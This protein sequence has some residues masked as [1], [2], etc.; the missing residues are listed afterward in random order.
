VGTQSPG[1]NIVITNNGIAEVAIASVSSPAAPFSI[2]TSTCV[3]LLPAGASCV[4]T[5]VFAPTSPTASS[6]TIV[7][8][9]E[10][11][12]V[13]T[14]LVGTGRTPTGP[15]PGFLTIKPVSANFGNAVVGTALPAKNFV[16]TNPGQSAVVVTSVG[17]G[18]T[19]ADQFTV[20]S[21]G[22]S[23]SLAAK[24]SC[25]IQVAATVTRDGAQTAT[26]DVLGAGGAAAHATLRI[27]GE[28]TP[29]LK[30]VPGVVSPGEV[31]TAIG[32]GF[33]PG[34]DVQL[35]FNGEAPF[36][37]VPTQADGTFRYSLLL[38]P[39]SVRIGGRQVVVV[40][41]PE[42]SG[43]FAP[44]LIELATSRP[45][46]FSNPQFTSGVRALITRGG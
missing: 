17:L 41:R 40:D 6:G 12:S 44:L 4:V 46:G 18:G 11:L 43:V 23:G 29:T 7:V 16:V 20:A 13:T 36:V 32:E 28:F 35:E 2:T 27:G 22:C 10:G 21:N 37:T 34:V 1:Q 33:P 38:V 9:G 3:G 39:H 45:S 24:A 42:F 30:M 5:V 15:T 14:S 31:T 26:L 19:G 25:T 8:S